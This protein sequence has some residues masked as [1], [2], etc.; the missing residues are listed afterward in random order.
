MVP[1]RAAAIFASDDIS[2]MSSGDDLDVS[3]IPA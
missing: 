2:S 1:A 3:T